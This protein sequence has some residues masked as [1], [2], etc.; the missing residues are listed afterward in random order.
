MQANNKVG[1]RT[2]QFPRLA[3]FFKLPFYKHYGA[4]VADISRAK[5]CGYE[6]IVLVHLPEFQEAHY[7]IIKKV[8]AKSIFFL[9]PWY[10]PQHRL[11]QKRFKETWHDNT[12]RVTKTRWFFALK[13]GVNIKK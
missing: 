13:D 8:T 7:S 12:H 6:I 11:T 4:T 10:G 1:T 5:N 2:D 9:D 3:R